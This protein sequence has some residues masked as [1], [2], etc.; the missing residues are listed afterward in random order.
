M[1][2]TEILKNN[3]II[4]VCLVFFYSCFS[5]QTKKDKV[6]NKININA[7]VDGYIHFYSDRKSSFNSKE[8]YLMLSII[9][10]QDLS[11]MQ[12]D[13]LDNCYNCPGP[14]I[15]KDMNVVQY[16]GYRIIIGTD[17]PNQQEFISKNF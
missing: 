17:I 7:I 9:K 6:K 16:K 12:I 15:T 3:L 14:E 4:L 2:H 1:R 5:S 13:I 10:N 8:R 11:K